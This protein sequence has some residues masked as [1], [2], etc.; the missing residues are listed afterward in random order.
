M[1][2]ATDPIKLVITKSTFKQKPQ[3]FVR[4]FKH[5]DRSRHATHGKV[6]CFAEEK[7]KKKIVC[8]HA[9]GIRVLVFILTTFPCYIVRNYIPLE[10]YID[11]L[12]C[13]FYIDSNA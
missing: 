7:K 5:T 9:S 3:P 12:Y 8:S 6:F 13:F 10:R 11:V 4:M 2:Q 1:V